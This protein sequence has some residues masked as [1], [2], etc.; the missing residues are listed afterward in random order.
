MP[1]DDGWLDATRVILRLQEGADR[2]ALRPV[3]RV[4]DALRLPQTKGDEW[5]VLWAYKPPWQHEPLKHRRRKGR[6]ASILLNHMP[7]TVRLASKV[8]L[9]EFT[10]TLT[11]KLPRLF[12]SI[13]PETYALPEEASR[14][15]DA[16]NRRGLHDA[17]GWPNWLAKSKQHRGIF[18]LSSGSNRSLAALGPTLVQ[19]RVRPL[20]LPG[21]RRAF[22]VGLYVMVSSVRPLHAWAFD[23]SLV[24]VCQRDY[25]RERAQ[26]GW[27]TAAFADKT[28]YVIKEY[29]PV[30]R[31]KYFAPFLAKCDGSAA[32][33]VR[34]A[35]DA[36]GYDGEGLW[37]R[38]RRIA[39]SLLL[40][41]RT[42]VEAGLRR[43]QLRGANVFEL[44]RFDFL[45]DEDGLPV[46]TEVN[47]S[48]NL[49]QAPNAPEDGE[50]KQQLL[51][52]T[53]GIATQRFTPAKSASSSPPTRRLALPSDVPASLHG[54]A[55]SP[56]CCTLQPGCNESW[57]RLSG[58]RCLSLHDVRMLQLAAAEQLA[59]KPAGMRRIWPTP[60]GSGSVRA[61]MQHSPPREDRLL[62]CWTRAAA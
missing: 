31:L 54:V 50:V 22:D 29:S 16:L 52:A 23:R 61:L 28:R 13:T 58:P 53:L 12:G 41:L 33:A 47:L 42:H 2:P 26:A 37:R 48:P 38:M 43:Q 45:I 3:A 18:V 10:R 56:E 55:C 21:L 60:M 25:P 59:A 11:A 35:L 51:R 24:R 34:A 17:F 6:N 4:A 36:H 49:V 46:L 7:G 14:F 32:C 40:A 30:W 44:F 8:H 19:E 27:A 62:A 9:I 57:A 20:L 1:V 15:A 5:S 39:A